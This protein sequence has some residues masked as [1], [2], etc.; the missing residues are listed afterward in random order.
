MDEYSHMFKMGKG[1]AMDKKTCENNKALLSFFPSP[2]F[3][4]CPKQAL[5]VKIIT[6]T[7]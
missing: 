3:L 7:S 2:F 5:T 6:W 4:T 1:R